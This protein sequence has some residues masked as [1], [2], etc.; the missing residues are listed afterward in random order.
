VSIA[1]A[2]IGT[3]TDAAVMSGT[4]M[5]SPLVAGV[6]ALA[7]QAHPKW[8]ASQI[9]TSLVNTSDP[10]KVSGSTVIDAGAGLVDPAQAVTNTTIVTGDQYRTK[11]GKVGEGTLSFGFTE[12]NIAFLGTKTFTITN[13]GPTAVT[14]SLSTTASPQSRPATVKLSTTKVRVPAGKSASV[15][16]VL[17][18]DARNIGSSQADSNDLFN[19]YQVSGNVVVTSNAGTLRVPYLLVPR[20]QTKVSGDLKLNR[21]P[22]G[23]SGTVSG[24]LRLSNFFGALNGTADVYTLGLTDGADAPGN[25]RGSGYDLRAAGVQSFDTSDGKLLVFAINNH[26]RW[27]NAASDEFDVLIDNNNDGKPDL[28]LLAADYGAYT[29]GEFNGITGAFVYDLATGD[30][31]STGFFPT[32][33]TDSSTILIPA[34]AS[35]LGLTET[36]GGFSYTV[37]SYSVEDAN[38][39]DEM[40]GWAKY[41]PWHRAISDGGYTSVPRNGTATLPITMD[42]AAAAAQKPKGVMVVSFDN[43]SGAKEALLLSAR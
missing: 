9:A 39:S 8:T 12:P 29:T 27:S 21:A 31:S 33:P 25:A 40:N 26:D 6:A 23:A 24:T 7:V 28:V 32:A 18:V 19:F 38:A 43:Q 35:Q 22:L 15:S 30:L 41:D 13:T 2:G 34:Y 17:A 4:S 11:S 36:G 37:Q 16:V 42:T 3:G 14:Y 10:E 20:A 1:S 5:A